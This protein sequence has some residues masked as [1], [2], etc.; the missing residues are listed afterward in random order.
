MRIGVILFLPALILGSCTRPEVSEFTDSPIIQAYLSPGDPFNVSITRQTPFSSE[1]VYSDDQIN[2]LAVNVDFNGVLYSL[3]P[4][5]EGKYVD[6]ALI[7]SENDSYTLSFHFNSKAVTALTYIPTKPE[8]VTLSKSEIFIDR[9]DSSSFGPPGSFP[10]PIE[11][12]WENPDNSYY[13]I[14]VE[15]V[16]STLDP[17][18]DFGDNDP[19]SIFFRKQPTT[20]NSE[21]IGFGEFQYYGTHRVVVYHVLPDYAALYDDNGTSSQ[22]LS[23]PS[24]SIVNGYGIFTGLNSDTLWIEVKES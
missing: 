14:L 11:I 5:G 15:N 3:H 1:V 22:N 21:E 16:E 10:D 23:N 18:R 7:V 6:S 8:D 12:S 4:V 24:S 19:P 13:L 2:D 9:V 17:I 20:L